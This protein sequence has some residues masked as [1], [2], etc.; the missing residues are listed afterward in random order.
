MILMLN[1]EKTTH[2]H[3][4][5]PDNTVKNLIPVPIRL[6]INNATKCKQ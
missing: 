3:K 2:T 5:D 6:A 1:W 4:N